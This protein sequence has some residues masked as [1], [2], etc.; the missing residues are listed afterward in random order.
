MQGNRMTARE[1]DRRICCGLLALLLPA[2]S[3]WAQE[4]GFEMPPAR[5]E[6]ATAEL[7][8]RFEPFAEELIGEAD[9][10]VAADPDGLLVRTETGYEVTERGR[11]F[12]RTI[13]SC[14]DTYLPGDNAKYSVGV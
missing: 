5:V 3:A 10:L 13:C 11:P 4:G 14:F 8:A 1:F 12:L 2:G 9:S 6:V 7:R